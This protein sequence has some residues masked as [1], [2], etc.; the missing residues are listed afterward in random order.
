[1]ADPVIE[2][3]AMT[4]EGGVIQGPRADTTADFN[5][6]QAIVSDND[7]NIIGNSMGGPCAHNEIGFTDHAVDDVDGVRR[8]MHGLKHIPRN[9]DNKN[10]LSWSRMVW[11]QAYER[12]PSPDG[13]SPFSVSLDPMWY[14]N[15]R[16]FVRHGGSGPP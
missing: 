6:N 11:A 9:A 1:M 16:L 4:F 3:V 5:G 13:G 2:P 7:S 10:M 15:Q 8:I 12:D 14:V